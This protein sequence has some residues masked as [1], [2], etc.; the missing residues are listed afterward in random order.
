MKK[1]RRKKIK[2]IPLPA[3]FDE[4]NQMLKAKFSVK[5]INYVTNNGIIRF[6]W[7][8]SNEQS[9]DE[10]I[11]L[12]KVQAAPIYILGRF[13]S[14]VV[15]WNAIKINMMGSLYKSGEES[16]KFRTDDFDIT[17]SKLTEWYKICNN[18]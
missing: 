3:S 15:S 11:K 12:L 7:L 16:D 6:G 8:I 1:S 9:I 17:K 2:T 10:A 13:A 4:T 14:A 18:E 5:Y